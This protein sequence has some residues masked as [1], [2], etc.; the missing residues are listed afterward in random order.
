ML[1]QAIVGVVSML[2][3]SSFRLTNTHQHWPIGTWVHLGVL[4]DV[5]V[6]HPW[7]Y[8]TKRKQ[9]L[10]SLNNG[11]YVWM[12]NRHAPVVV[13]TEGLVRNTLSAP[14]ITGKNRIPI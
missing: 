10:R 7:T 1:V 8:N 12:G 11:E 13:T 6:W 14:L 2:T 4:H 3:L 5:P 9:C